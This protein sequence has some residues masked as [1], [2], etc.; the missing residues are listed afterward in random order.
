MP[1]KTSRIISAGMA[2]FAMFFGSGNLVFPL[3]LGIETQSKTHMSLIGL[4]STSI[5]VPFLGVLSM[6]M[7]HGSF[8]LF[9]RWLGKIPKLLVC[10]CIIALIG[11]F[12]VIPR[13]ITISHAS[14]QNYFPGLS[15]ITFS[16]VV[17]I[18]MFFAT[19]KKGRYLGVIGKVL[20]PTLLVVLGIIITK[21]I[22]SPNTAD[23]SNYTNSKALFKGV[24]EGYNTMDLLATFFFTKSVLHYFENKNHT[25]PMTTIVKTTLKAGLVGLG[26]LT[27]IYCAFSFLGAQYSHVLK[28]VAPEHLLTY[29]SIYIL[30]PA[31]GVLASVAIA[32]ACFTTALALVEVSS[33]FLINEICKGKLKKSY[34]LIIILTLSI[35][36]S[37]FKF[38]GIAAFLTPI[39]Q[40]SYPFLIGLTLL[41]IGN[42]IIKRKHPL[43]EGMVK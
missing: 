37:T 15:L 16:V 17:C 20:A 25:T 3:Y 31:G 7:L 12:G 24:V 11:P 33:E 30:G 8:Q 35:V 39:L 21:G 9:F 42:R 18:I 29:L 10:T 13:C 36:V 1:S 26:L 34:S 14:I 41:N 22:L 40:F 32:L 23:V 4:L 19:M 6:V 38:S 43:E 5:I 28:N 27:V 2:L